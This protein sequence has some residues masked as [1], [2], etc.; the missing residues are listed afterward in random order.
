MKTF[1]LLLRG[2][3]VGGHKKIKMAELKKQL[4]G[5]KLKDVQTYIQSGNV[6]F[7]SE[8]NSIVALTGE[9]ENMIKEN[10]SFEAKAL[11]LTKQKFEAIFN[12]N[13]YLSQKQNEQEK[14]YC[15]LFFQTPE[16]EKLDLLKLINT[17]GDEFIEGDN[18][19]YFYYNNGYGK[20]KINNPVIENK[21]KV[22]AT[23]RNWKTMT[24]LR[25]MAL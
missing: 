5:L 7:K 17:D 10:Y 11:V 21:I 9:I 25:E 19:L 18:C 4:E 22:L 20:S 13:P 24:K 8:K 23:T 3:N 16:K 12:K 15:T 14:L 6:V 1:I 2:I